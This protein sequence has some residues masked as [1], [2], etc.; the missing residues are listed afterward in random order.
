[1]RLK[2]RGSASAPNMQEDAPG[3]AHLE[4]CLSDYPS[5][6][7]ARGYASSRLDDV[8]DSRPTSGLSLVLKDLRERSRRFER[9]TRK[10]DSA[11]KGTSANSRKESEFRVKREN[12]A[13]RSW[14]LW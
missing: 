12:K 6:L 1:M 13:M 11:E 3:C 8:L 9:T 7:L 2:S 4:H 5:L 14:F 10:N